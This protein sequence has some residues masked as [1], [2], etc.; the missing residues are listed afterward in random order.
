VLYG[1]SY[2]PVDLRAVEAAWAC[3]GALALMTVY[4]NE[5][6]WDRSNCILREGRVVLYDKSRPVNRRAEMRWI[7]YGLSVFRR[8]VLLDR[9]PPG[10]AADLADLQ[11][12]LS[13]AGELRGHEVRERFYEAGSPAGLRDLEQYLGSCGRSR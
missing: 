4:R 8:A 11:R 12:E 7:D 1:D 6:R 9:V 10:V 13:I 3:P 5:E 2:L